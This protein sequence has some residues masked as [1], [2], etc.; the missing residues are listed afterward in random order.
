MDKRLESYDFTTGMLIDSVVDDLKDGSIDSKEYVR[1]HFSLEERFETLSEQHNKALA[2][3]ERHKQDI[4]EIHFQ[5]SLV[6]TSD[7]V[8]NA[9]IQ[10]LKGV[11]G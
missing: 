7:N 10:A 11:E 1:E 5:A 6:E 4:N 8:Y 3:I 9:I 2:Q